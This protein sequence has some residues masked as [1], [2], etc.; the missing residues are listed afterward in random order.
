M[1]FTSFDIKINSDTLTDRE[2]NKILS[3]D[4]QSIDISGC[5]MLTSESMLNIHYVCLKLRY[6]NLDG[7]TGITANDIMCVIGRCKYLEKIVL[8]SSHISD[9][10]MGTISV[11]ATNL[12]CLIK[13]YE[14]DAIVYKRV[15]R[16][17]KHQDDQRK[18]LTNYLK[19]KCDR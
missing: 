7:C 13:T 19:C 5:K 4:V 12:I 14:N 1:L 10:L 17:S 9:C 8:D 11:Y 16:D 15:F 6:L 2:F 18:I 3:P